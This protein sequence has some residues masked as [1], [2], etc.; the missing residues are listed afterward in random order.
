[1]TYTAMTA[2]DQA[3]VRITN[4][5]HHPLPSYATARSAGTD[6]HA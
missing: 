6:A 4:R 2:T 3:T 1:M 5:S